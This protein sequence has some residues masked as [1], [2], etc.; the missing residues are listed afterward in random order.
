MRRSLYCIVALLLMAAPALAQESLKIAV[1]DTVAV[2][3][4]MQ[5]TKDL[6]QKMDADRRTV[7]ATDQQRAQQVQAKK[8]ERDQLKPDSPQYQQRNDEF[9]HAAIDYK[10]W[11]ELTKLEIERRQKDQ[12]RHLY[13]EIQ[14]AVTEIARHKGLDLVLIQEDIQIPANLEGITVD[15]LN[16]L[17]SQQNMM[18]VSDK[19]SITNEVIAYLDAQYKKTTGQ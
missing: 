10:A 8:D 13:Q 1:V 19:A 12:I 11:Q 3:N 16:R 5:E 18:F 4:Q 7:Q 17:I 9:L 2:F 15:Q 6:K 14:D